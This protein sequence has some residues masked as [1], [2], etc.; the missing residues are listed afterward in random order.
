MSAANLEEKYIPRLL[1]RYREEIVPKMKEVFGY[2]NDLAVPRLE[3]ISIN[4]GVGA[5]MND[6]KII[7]RA[8]EELSMISGQKA[9]ICKAK[10]P[11]SNFK[12]REGVAIGC[13]VLLR[14]YRMY[15]F[16]DR[17]ISVA[18]P[19]IRDFRGF[20]VKSFDNQGNYNFGLVDQMIF[21][22]INVDKASR[23]QGMNI[24]IVTTAKTD[25]EA[26]QLLTLMGFPFK[27]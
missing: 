24:T 10:K 26:K 27:K 13:C 8:A 17:M 11:I 15:D 25:E 1:K 21:P 14:R 6:Q 16:L 19:R 23:T 4:M 12:L 2:T 9:K 18:M 3:K 7:E 5:A 20:S 22:E